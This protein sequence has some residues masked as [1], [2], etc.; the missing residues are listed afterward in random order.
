LNHHKGNGSIDA[1][2]KSYITRVLANII[3]ASVLIITLAVVVA[4][5]YWRAKIG[6]VD[7]SSGRNA[8][9]VIA[10]IV[11]RNGNSSAYTASKRITSVGEAHISSSTRR[12][13]SMHTNCG[14]RN[15]RISLVANINSTGI[16]VI[17]VSATKSTLG[18]RTSRAVSHD[19]S[20]CRNTRNFGATISDKRKRDWGLDTTSNFITC[21]GVANINSNT[22]DESI[23]TEVL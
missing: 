17:T 6:I 18:D 5:R 12:D 2:G 23:G 7:H 13:G 15:C 1:L 22:R 20:L 4:I 14:R 8:L 10:H 19:T 3:G 9:V 11:R 21:S 16:L